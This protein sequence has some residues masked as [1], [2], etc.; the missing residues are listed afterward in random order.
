MILP[1]LLLNQ[2]KEATNVKVEKL[3]LPKVH[4]NHIY[5]YSINQRL[6][7]D[8]PIS[9]VSAEIIIYRVELKYV[10]VTLYLR[11]FSY[12]RVFY[13]SRTFSYICNNN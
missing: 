12:V 10:V 5:L 7:M 2:N 4:L 9:L 13:L 11:T 3:I 6:V 1:A 8:N